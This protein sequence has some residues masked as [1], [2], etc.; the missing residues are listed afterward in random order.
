[1]FL[2]YKYVAIIAMLAEVNFCADKLELPGGHPIL[3]NQLR[4]A[5]VAPPK[6]M[7]FGGRLDSERYSFCFS[8]TGRL[9]Y[10]TKLNP[11]GDLNVADQN[12]ALSRERSLINTNDAYTLATNWLALMAVDVRELQKTNVV[13][14]QQRFCYSE[15]ATSGKVLLPIWYVKWGMW[16]DPTVNVS[17]DGRNKELLYLRLEDDSF[18]KRPV[19]LIRDREKLLSIPDDEFMKY[20]SAQQSNLVTQFAAVSYPVGS[21]PLAS[22]NVSIST[23]LPSSKSLPLPAA[24][25]SVIKKQEN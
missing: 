9:R 25:L 13:E 12:R 23:N 20:S 7:N 22:T 19:G 17:I 15:E 16:S 11:F 4:V 24:P 18:S 14:V 21:A 1:M 2:A 5:S 6:I 3:P 8:E 10:I